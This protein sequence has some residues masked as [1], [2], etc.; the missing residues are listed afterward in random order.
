[1][2]TGAIDENIANHAPMFVTYAVDVRWRLIFGGCA[3]KE[4]DPRTGRG[5]LEMYICQACGFIEWYC[6]NP[7]EVPIGPQ[8]MTEIIDCAGSGPY[9]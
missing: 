5:V 6:Q 3:V 2:S 1:M 7:T 9:R 4:I 8:Y